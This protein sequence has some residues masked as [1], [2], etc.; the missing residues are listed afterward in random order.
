MHKAFLRALQLTNAR[1][2]DVKQHTSFYDN[3]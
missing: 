1:F 2:V 3:S